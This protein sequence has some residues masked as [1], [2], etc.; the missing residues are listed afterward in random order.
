[1]PQRLTAGALAGMTATS[2]THPLDTL[3][4]RLAMPT[5]GY[6]G[7]TNALVTIVKNVSEGERI[8]FRGT[9]SFAS[10]PAAMSH[11]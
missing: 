11:R 6:T 9:A 10:R 2:L 3:R 1:M 8:P 7:M 4:L 5:S